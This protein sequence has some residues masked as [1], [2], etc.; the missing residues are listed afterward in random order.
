MKTKIPDAHLRR[1]Q[2]VN[3]YGLQA[4]DGFATHVCDFMMD[5]KSWAIQQLVIK[6][7]H[8][9]TGKEV[10]IPMNQ[11]DGISYQDSTIFVKLTTDAVEKSPEQHLAPN[12]TAVSAKP[13]LAL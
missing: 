1:M 12:G 4:T 11:I 2:A 10:Q 6:T 9:F 8:R 5:D 13:I 7:G 3:G